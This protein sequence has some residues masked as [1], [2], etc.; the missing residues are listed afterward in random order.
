MYKDYRNII[1]A[2]NAESSKFEI[3]TGLVQRCTVLNSNRWNDGWSGNTETYTSDKKV[4]RA[5][6]INF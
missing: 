5:T 3:K 4:L 2:N 1:R 6:N